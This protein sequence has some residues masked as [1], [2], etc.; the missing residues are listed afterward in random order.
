MPLSEKVAPVDDDGGDFTAYDATVRSPRL[1][2]NTTTI[3]SATLDDVDEL[4]RLAVAENR[5]SPSDGRGS[6]SLEFWR[7][8]FTNNLGRHDRHVKVAEAATGLVGYGRTGWYDPASD[9]PA[10]TAPAGWYLNGLSVEPDWR[11]RGIARTL[12]A[13]RLDWVAARADAAWYFANAQNRVSL[14][15]HASL[16]FVEVTRDFSFPGA[17]FPG[18]AGVLCRVD[19]TGRW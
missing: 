17:E 5:R 16:G 1:D 4:A 9:A 14:A 6:T 7:N 11:R 8:L 2:P 12:T 3:R 13:E 15:L 10:N 18:G 19:L